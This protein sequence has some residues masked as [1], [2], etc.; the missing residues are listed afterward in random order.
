M[1]ARLRRKTHVDTNEHMHGSDEAALTAVSVCGVEKFLKKKK[2]GFKKIF[3]NKAA[4]EC[5]GSAER[6]A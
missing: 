6:P 4:E 5:G 3:F 1:S 2:G